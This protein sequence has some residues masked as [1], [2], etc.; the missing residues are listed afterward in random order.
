MK[1]KLRTVIVLF[2]LF[3]CWTFL[4][5]TVDWYF[6]IPESKKDM[7][8]LSRDEIEKLSKDKKTE[9]LKLKKKRRKVINMG[10]DL[11]GGLYMVLSVRDAQLSNYLQ[12]KYLDQ[13]KNQDEYKD[14]ANN[15]P[16]LQQ[17]IA[18]MIKNNYAAEKSQAAESA[19]TRIGGRVDQF[20]ISEPVIQKGADNR[21]YI[22][23]AGIKDP[24]AAEEIVSKAGR[25]TFQLLDT[26][27]MKKF[28][29][30]YYKSNPEYFTV[31]DNQAL[32]NPATNLPAQFKMPDESELLYLWKRNEF[33]IPKKQGGVFIK[34]KVLMDGAVIK[35][36]Q[37]TFDQYQNKMQVA[38]T[39]KSEGIKQFANITGENIGKHLAIILDNRVQSY[40]TIQSKIAGGSG[41]ITGNFTPQEAKNLAAILTAGSFNVS[42]RVEE[43]RTVGPS[44]G[45]DSIRSGVTAILIGFGLVVIFML[46]YYKFAGLVADFALL[47]N[48]VIVFAI[49]TQLGATLTLPGIAGLI[50][51]LGMS[52]DAN[53]IVFERIKEELRSGNSQ[54]RVSIGKG[55]NRAFRTILDANLTTLLAA[56]V[57]MQLG[58]GAIKGF[59]VTLFIGILSSMF[60]ALFVSRYLIDGSVALFKM[61]KLS[62]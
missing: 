16:K 57:L 2:S 29:D 24:Q 14:L 22:S 3:L 39:L 53:V 32:I 55:F 8:R 25:L 7:I 1:F 60:T 40:P 9:I 51:T 42:L 17:K 15:N 27:T 31:V 41:V 10:L 46:V 6:N 44:L 35:Y 62:I 61:K 56:L 54:L 48:M 49:M 20:G 59:A 33:G 18:E 19:Y 21:I 13:L 37:P 34:K 28:Y 23:L 36:A 11:Q 30:K 52:V 47:L 45:R 12:Q 38:F 5:D 50:L 43:K 4:K 58:T 26:E